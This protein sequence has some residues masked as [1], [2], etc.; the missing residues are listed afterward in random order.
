[1]IYWCAFLILK[2]KGNECMIICFRAS[3]VWTFLGKREDSRL[4]HM[5][6]C[7]RQSWALA[8]ACP[9]KSLPCC[10]SSSYIGWNWCSSDILVGLHHLQKPGS[11]NAPMKVQLLVLILILVP[12]QK[13]R[14]RRGGWLGRG[15]RA[16]SQPRSWRCQWRRCS[17]FWE[18]PKTWIWVLLMSTCVCCYAPFDVLAQSVDCLS[19]TER[20]VSSH[21]GTEGNCLCSLSLQFSSSSDSLRFGATENGRKYPPLVSVSERLGVG[22][23]DRWCHCTI[24]SLK[25]VSSPCLHWA[26]F[27][28][29][30]RP[31]FFS[32]GDLYF[33]WVSLPFQLFLFSWL[34]FPALPPIVVSLLV[35]LKL[36]LSYLQ[37]RCLF[38]TWNSWNVGRSGPL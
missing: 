38:P 7:C 18:R 3:P 14:R 32:W 26:A 8:S 34:S 25:D 19:A 27:R 10:S 30:P 24:D 21:L 28:I 29:C 20:S 33:F 1:M 5:L 15:C 23:S 6:Q 36:C 11:M 37:R 9:A 2:T 35:E 22:H 12:N 4:S 31:W 16:N 17:S 13:H